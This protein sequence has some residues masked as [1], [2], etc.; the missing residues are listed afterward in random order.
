MA[1]HTPGPWQPRFLY[2][3]IKAARET[4]GLLIATDPANDWADACLM[5]AAPDMLHALRETLDCI[6]VNY[7]GVD[8]CPPCLE[9][10]RAAVSKA[11]GRRPP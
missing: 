3:M 8:V 6:E 7:V 11:E 2:R 10:A 5:A 1:E 4:P 9:L